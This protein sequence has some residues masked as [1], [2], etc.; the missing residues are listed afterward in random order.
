MQKMPYLTFNACVT[1]LYPSDALLI[2]SQTGEKFQAAGPE[3][4]QCGAHVLSQPVILHQLGIDPSPCHLFFHEATF[5]HGPQLLL[6]RHLTLQARYL[7]TPLSGGG[8][9]QP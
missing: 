8:V 9:V 6:L 4:C 5:H 1:S 2:S 7:F 3:L